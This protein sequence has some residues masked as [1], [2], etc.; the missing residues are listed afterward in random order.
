[1][2][3]YYYWNYDKFLYSWFY[4]GEIISNITVSIESYLE[5]LFIGDT[6]YTWSSKNYAVNW[7]GIFFSNDVIGLDYLTLL[8]V[9]ID[10]LSSIKSSGLSKISLFLGLLLL[11]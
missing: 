9:R 1:M 10:F 3:N 2:G 11:F 6:F 7:G 4:L 8:I 5:Y